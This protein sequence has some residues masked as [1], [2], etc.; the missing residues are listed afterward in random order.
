MS[1]S[2][3]GHH[4]IDDI[5]ACCIRDEALRVGCP[6][7]LAMGIA[8]AE[9]GWDPN[10]L[11]DGGLSYGLFQLYVAGG[12]GSEYRDN[13]TLL[14]NPRLNSRIA[15]VPI[16]QAAWKCTVAGEQGVDFI[17]CVAVHSGHPGHISTS[18]PR[19]Q[20][21]VR[22]TL[23]VVFDRYG[24]FARWPTLR[25]SDCA[26]VTIPV[27]GVPTPPPPMPG[28]SDVQPVE[29]PL[30]AQDGVMGLSPVEPPAALQ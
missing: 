3:Y 14:F 10:A 25:R 11:G 23:E 18:D 8:G 27:P 24:N 19:V 30:E 7:Y 13:P 21:I 9:S 28:W 12:Q 16:A 2:L 1:S 15:V 17:A 22:I 20:R 6:E 26:G 4:R 5:V 29:P